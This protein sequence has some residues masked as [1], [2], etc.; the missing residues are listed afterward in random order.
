LFERVELLGKDLVAYFAEVYEKE[1]RFCAMFISE[2]YVRKAWTQLERQHA[3][4]RALLKRRNT[5]C[6]CASTTLKYPAY[7][8][9]FAASTN[10]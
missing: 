9:P 5:S 8:P 2:H 4:S 1:A 3:R 7:Q 6:R 10:R